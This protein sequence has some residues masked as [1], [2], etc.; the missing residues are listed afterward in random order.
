MQRY[1]FTYFSAPAKCNHRCQSSRPMDHQWASLVWQSWVLRW[2]GL[3]QSH[4]CWEDQGS[5]SVRECRQWWRL[6]LVWHTRDYER[7][8]LYCEGGRRGQHSWLC[9]HKVLPLYCYKYKYDA[10]WN[11]DYYSDW[12][13][14]SEVSSVML[15]DILLKFK[16]RYCLNYLPT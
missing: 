11:Y 8:H 5:D 14:W 12:H 16:V 1:S 15:L 9:S 2:T 4:W 10:A 13:L 3:P 6:G 7:L